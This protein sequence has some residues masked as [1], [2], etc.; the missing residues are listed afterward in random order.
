MFSTPPNLIRL[1]FLQSNWV[2]FSP[3]TLGF[4][5][6]CKHLGWCQLLSHEA[7]ICIQPS[8]ALASAKGLPYLWGLGAHST[9]L[10][11]GNEVSRKVRGGWRRQRRKLFLLVLSRVWK[12]KRGLRART[13]RSYLQFCPSLPIPPWI[14]WV[15]MGPTFLICGKLDSHS[16]SFVLRWV[17]IKFSR[18]WPD[19]CLT[20][21]GW[22]V[23][24]TGQKVHPSRYTYTFFKKLKEETELVPLKNCLQSVSF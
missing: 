3:C 24:H 19:D 22:Q 8:P 18:L 20:R 13:P 21:R 10:T 9:S 12:K 7:A 17:G 2:I 1:L 15:R 14:I 6:A 11:S 23:W 16:E 4:S 5:T